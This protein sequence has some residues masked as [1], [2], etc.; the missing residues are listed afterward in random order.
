MKLLIVYESKYGYPNYHALAI[1][2]Y[3][4]YFNLT[5]I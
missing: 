2:N 3:L 1:L 5:M 4:N